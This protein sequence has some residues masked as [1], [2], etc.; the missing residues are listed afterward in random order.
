[1]QSVD[2]LIKE[3]SARQADKEQELSG[4][5]QLVQAEIERAAEAQVVEVSRYMRRTASRRC[6]KASSRSFGGRI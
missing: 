5:A 6:S 4:L 3:E 2:P 1:M